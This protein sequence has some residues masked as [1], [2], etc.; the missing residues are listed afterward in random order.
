MQVLAAGKPLINRPL[1]SVMFTYARIDRYLRTPSIAG[2]KCS[3]AAKCARPLALEAL[4][5]R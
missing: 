1:P 3:C 5:A 2:D 4:F